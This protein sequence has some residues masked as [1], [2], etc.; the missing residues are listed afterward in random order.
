M[1]DGEIPERLAAL[2]I[3]LKHVLDNFGS[4]NS[5]PDAAD[6][7][8]AIRSIVVVVDELAHIVTE[9]ADIP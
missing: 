2:R 9:L 8:E 5:Y 7:D 1:T 4:D 6:Q 3:R